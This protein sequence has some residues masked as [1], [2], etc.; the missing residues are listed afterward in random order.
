MARYLTQFVRIKQLLGFSEIA[1][2]VTYSLRNK[3]ACK[4]ILDHNLRF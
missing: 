3:I 2:L 4:K 1:T